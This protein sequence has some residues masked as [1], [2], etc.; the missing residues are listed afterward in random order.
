MPTATAKSWP[1]SLFIR[2]SDCWRCYVS[3]QVR[4]KRELLGV[5]GTLDTNGLAGC[6]VALGTA[7][8][9]ATSSS[10]RTPPQHSPE[11]EGKLPTAVRC[12]PWTTSSHF[13]SD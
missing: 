8:R 5:G 6:Y 9:L 1:A 3:A 7:V 13:L 12:S 11:C 4:R 10:F 2:S